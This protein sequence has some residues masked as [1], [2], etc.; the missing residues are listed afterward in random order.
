M[1]QTVVQKRKE[2]IA[3]AIS[4]YFDYG[5]YGTIKEYKTACYEKLFRLGYYD[6]YIQFDP[7][8]KENN[9]E[10]TSK[11]REKFDAEW[12]SEAKKFKR[13]LRSIGYVE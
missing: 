11:C 13:F 5:V 8:A 6:K 3:K 1:A 9:Y 10:D 7:E 2:V 4:E 12:V